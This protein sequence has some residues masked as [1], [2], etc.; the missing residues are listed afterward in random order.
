MATISSAYLEFVERYLNERSFA[1]CVHIE[2]PI[3]G[4]K[5]NFDPKIDRAFRDFKF[6]PTGKRKV[7]RTGDWWINDR[8]N[9]LFDQRGEYYPRLHRNRQYEKILS[10]LK[11]Y[12]KQT[13]NANCYV[14]ILFNPTSDLHCSKTNP[15]II[16]RMPKPPCLTMLQF[17]PKVMRMRKIKELSL[18][19]HFRA[20]YIDTKAY[21]NILSLAELLKRTCNRTGFEV[22]SL[23]SVASRLIAKHNAKT[24]KELHRGLKKEHN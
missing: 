11:D 2:K 12:Q 23:H 1:M 10:S 8:M 6:P 4:G 18:C 24:V 14:L 21:G 20:Q 5:L 19:A 13:W 16:T 17:L 7:V 9:A 3:K 15:S 22:G